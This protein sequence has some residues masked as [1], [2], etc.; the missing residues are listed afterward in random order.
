M[1]EDEEKGFSMR[2]LSFEDLLSVDKAEVLADIKES[3]SKLGKFTLRDMMEAIYGERF[4]LS[5]LGRS[6]GNI[7]MEDLRV[8][9]S[10]G[11]DGLHTKI[12]KDQMKE[13]FGDAHPDQSPEQI[14]EMVDPPDHNEAAAAAMEDEL[15]AMSPEERQLILKF[16]RSVSTIKERK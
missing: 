15:K 10:T 7:L 13:I 4:T 1:S 11:K 6:G 16:M 2:G 14:K 3:R 8:E 5:V 12:S 9:Y